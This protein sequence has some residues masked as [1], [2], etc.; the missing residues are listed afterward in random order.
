MTPTADPQQERSHS[1]RYCY[2]LDTQGR[3]L[4]SALSEPSWDVELCTAPGLLQ[5]QVLGV[6]LH[7]CMCACRKSGASLG[8]PHSVPGWRS[9]LNQ[10]MMHTAT[11]V[12][13]TYPHSGEHV[14]TRC[15]VCSSEPWDLDLMRMSFI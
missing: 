9:P 8:V 3:V 1:H 10:K 14:S 2:F 7:T 13:P 4:S 5:C 15:R 11:G 6:P 12:S